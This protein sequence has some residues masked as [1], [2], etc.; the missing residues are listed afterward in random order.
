MNCPCQGLKI[1]I[2]QKLLSKTKTDDARL[3]ELIGEA[4]HST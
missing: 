3:F 1:T 2:P 4:Q